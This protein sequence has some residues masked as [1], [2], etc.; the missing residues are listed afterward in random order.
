LSL[1]GLSAPVL[2]GAAGQSL[3]SLV[4]QVNAPGR[5]GTAIK[6]GSNYKPAPVTGSRRPGFASRA[7]AAKPHGGG[8]SPLLALPVVLLLLAP[9]GLAITGRPPR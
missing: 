4:A 5:T 3:P 7:P 1:F 9:L 8:F 6:S 2:P